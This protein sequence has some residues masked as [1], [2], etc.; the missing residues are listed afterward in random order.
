MLFWANKLPYYGRRGTVWVCLWE[1]EEAYNAF[2]GLSQID[3]NTKFVDV[4]VDGGESLV[5]GDRM[6]KGQVQRAVGAKVHM[7]GHMGGGERRR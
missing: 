4:S 1:N 3:F 2:Q 7:E 6:V 5:A